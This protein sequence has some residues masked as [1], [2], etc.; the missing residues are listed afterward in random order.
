MREE[1][2]TKIKI[3]SISQGSIPYLGS[4]WAL[5]DSHELIHLADK[6]MYFTSRQVFSVTPMLHVGTEESDM[7]PC[8]HSQ[9][10]RG[11]NVPEI[12]R[13]EKS[14]GRKR[15]TENLSG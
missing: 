7:R 12:R 2:T 1:R 14:K 8:T 9:Q 6:I 15:R 5:P 4:E 3:R 11:M 13:R 10:S